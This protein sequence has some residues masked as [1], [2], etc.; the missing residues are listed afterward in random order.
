MVTETALADPQATGWRRVGD[1]DSCAFCRMLI[2]RGEVYSE[3]GVT[4]ASHDRCGCEAE[5]AYG[6]GERVSV[7]QYTASKR[8]QTDADRAR[9]REWLR[10]HDV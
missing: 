2:G 6:D 10:E 3:A 9:V 5:P 4:F 1:G 7:K 8:K